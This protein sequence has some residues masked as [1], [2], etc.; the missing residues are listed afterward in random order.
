MGLRSLFYAKC[1]LGLDSVSLGSTI[2]LG[3]LRVPQFV[4]CL[5]RESTNLFF[6]L[7]CIDRQPDVT[8]IPEPS[9]IALFA[10]GSLAL[11]SRGRS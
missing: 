11:L 8:L 3:C 6:S 9:Y 2:I 4:I 10:L 7:D 1:L 5:C